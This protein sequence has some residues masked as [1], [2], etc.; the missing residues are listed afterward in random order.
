MII[1]SSS[2]KSNKKHKASLGE[3]Y[4]GQVECAFSMVGEGLGGSAVGA[5]I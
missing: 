2:D 5:Q 1:M 3:N 4:L